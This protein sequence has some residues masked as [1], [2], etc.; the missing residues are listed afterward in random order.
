MKAFYRHVSMCAAQGI[1]VNVNTYGGAGFGGN[2]IAWAART[3]SPLT[4]LGRQNRTGL[5]IP[6]TANASGSTNAQLNVTMGTMLGQKKV[7][8]FKH[9]YVFGF[10]DPSGAVPSSSGWVSVGRFGM[11]NETHFTQLQNLALG[12]RPTDANLKIFHAGTAAQPPID[13]G[14]DFTKDTQI[15]ATYEFVLE[16]EPGSTNV[17]W[18]VTRL[19]TLVPIV[20]TGVIAGTPA[21]V[22]DPQYV[23]VHRAGRNNGGELKLTGIDFISMVTEVLMS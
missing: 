23:L 17:K 4:Y 3:F 5:N 21:T 13:L 9:T 20:A 7:G 2:G 10:F 19:D 14:P 15:G 18:T 1:G 12:F 6:A 16:I 11:Q 22:P 8:G